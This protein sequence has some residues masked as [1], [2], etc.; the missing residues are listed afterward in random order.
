MRSGPWRYVFTYHVVAPARVARCIQQRVTGDRVC[1][2]ITTHRRVHERRAAPPH[3]HL[4]CRQLADS[5]LRLVDLVVDLQFGLLWF[6][7]LN[8]QPG[9]DEGS[10]CQP[11]SSPVVACA[12]QLGDIR[13]SGITMDEIGMPGAAAHFVAAGPPGRTMQERRNVPRTPEDFLQQLPALVLLDR[14]STPTLIT[15]LD[16]SSS[17][18]TLRAGNCSATDTAG[19]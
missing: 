8:K 16:G 2:V 15:G 9:R 3:E 13:S 4:A 5:M 10:R 1:M 19:G 7:T 6:S 11:P 12:D 14:L 18:P 17:T